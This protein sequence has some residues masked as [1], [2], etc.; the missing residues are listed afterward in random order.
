MVLG[1][2]SFYNVIGEEINRSILVQAMIDSYNEKY[3]NVDITDFNEGFE[4]RNMLESFSVDI[5]HLEKNDTDLLRAAFLS[6]SYGRY[7][8]LFGE[9]YNTPRDYGSIS[10]GVVLFSIPEPIDY[11]VV[12]PVN[13]VLV[14]NETG[15]EY[16]TSI[17][18]EIPIGETSVECVV[19]SQVVGLNTNANPN[20]I[21]IFKDT[22]PYNML[23]VNNPDTFTGGKDS[24]TDDEYRSRL[25]KVKG[26]D[27]FGSKEHY[28]RLGESI[29]GV[30]DVIIVNS[31][32]N[33]T[34]KVIVNGDNK[35]LSSDILTL[36]V[37]QYTTQKN[38]VYD[39]SFEVE[40]VDYTT[41]NLELEMSV[42]E[43]LSDNT[44]IGAINSLFNGGS[45]SNGL[46]VGLNINQALSKYLILNCIESVNGVIQV[47]ELTSDNNSFNRLIP[48]ENT[49]LMLG[50]VT[51]IQNIE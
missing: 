11:N 28:H 32:N 41:V 20:S 14:S 24:E 42:T 10:W 34:G 40:P 49:V 38:L 5:Y 23:S 43:Q 29:D 37:A 15:L 30:H 3:P 16:L 35:P 36:V 8:D 46:Y 2:E 45:Y 7:L 47:T 51:I 17:E 12:I 31:E 19:Y 27:S 48:D 1:D 33:Y 22:A 50:N 39:H 9:E 6:T 4:I 25:L 21:T 44:I 13:T 26:Q 18:V